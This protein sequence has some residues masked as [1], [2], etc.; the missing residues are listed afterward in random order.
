[1]FL[2]RPP[3]NYKNLAVEI[4]N[5]TRSRWYLGS[6]VKDAKLPPQ[7]NL[8]VA[9]KKA[10]MGKFLARYQNGPEIDSKKSQKSNFNQRI[11]RRGDILFF[12]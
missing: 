3:C 5:I 12:Y 11:G 2:K 7:A 9:F 6:L 4:R 8:K 10:D 1:M